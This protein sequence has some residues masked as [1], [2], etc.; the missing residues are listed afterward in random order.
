MSSPRSPDYPPRVST[1]PLNPHATFATSVGV[2]SSKNENRGSVDAGKCNSRVKAVSHQT[3]P[4]GESFEAITSSAKS[5]CSNETNSCSKE[6]DSQGN[7]KDCRG[8]G[9]MCKEH[10]ES[11]TGEEKKSIEEKKVST[12]ATKMESEVFSTKIERNVEE[13]MEEAQ[14]HVK[15]EEEN[16]IE[17]KTETNESLWSENVRKMEDSGSIDSTTPQDQSKSAET[18]CTVTTRSTNE[19][20]QGKTSARVISSTTEKRSSKEHS[21]RRH[22]SRCYKRS[23]IKRASIGVQCKRDRT[24]HPLQQHKQMTGTFQKSNS[25]NLRLNLGTKNCKTLNANEIAIKH[26]QLEHL[27]YKKFIHIETYPNGGATAVHMYQDEIS[28][29]SKEQVEELA[30]EYFKVKKHVFL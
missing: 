24:S 27:K 9:K 6:R 26:E 29:L 25:E 3:P 12:V 20:T 2:E 7:E 16:K 14:S 10:A 17:V 18:V 19:Q 1:S 11:R 30:Q 5:C 8:D 23:K 21:D 4:T 22:C 15:N 28:I 13:S